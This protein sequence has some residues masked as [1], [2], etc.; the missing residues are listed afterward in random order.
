MALYFTIGLS[1]L[2]GSEPGGLS[3][4]WWDM[5]DSVDLIIFVRFRKS[6]LSVSRYSKLKCKYIFSTVSILKYEPLID[7]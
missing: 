2:A 1:L 5:Q 6:T 4:I 3:P 7:K